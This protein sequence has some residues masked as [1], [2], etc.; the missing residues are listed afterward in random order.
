MRYLAALMSLPLMACGPNLIG[1]WVG[2][3]EFN[4]YDVEVEVEIKDEDKGEVSGDAKA[5]L[6]FTDGSGADPI[7]YD[8]E[9]EGS[10]EDNELDIELELVAMDGSN[11]TFT[12]EAEYN[13][14]RLEF[15]GECKNGGEDGDIELEFDD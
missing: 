9:F 1:D 2:T 4:Q 5:Q 3:C 11:G 14:D 6:L 13:K 8:G 15:E 12:I 7:F 10:F